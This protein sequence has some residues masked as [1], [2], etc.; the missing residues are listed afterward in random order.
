MGITESIRLNF[1]NLKERWVRLMKLDKNSEV[2]T[3]QSIGLV[4][5][6]LPKKNP[7]VTQN[8]RR[9]GSVKRRYSEITSIVT[10]GLEGLP[11]YHKQ[12]KWLSSRPD[13]T[14][15]KSIR[16]SDVVMIRPVQRG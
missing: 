9:Q 12:S 16:I 4:V 11:A 8:A 14:C 5:L 7:R 13:P 1:E 3:F 6:D 15:Y 2:T 10:L